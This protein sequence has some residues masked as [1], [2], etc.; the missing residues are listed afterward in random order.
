MQPAWHEQN[1]S[2]AHTHTVSFKYWHTEYRTKTFCCAPE[3]RHLLFSFYI[4]RAHSE[5]RTD[6]VLV[7]VIAAFSNSTR[8]KNKHN[9]SLHSSHQLVHEENSSKICKISYSNSRV[10]S[11]HDLLYQTNSTR[12][13]N[14]IN[15]CTKFSYLTARNLVTIIT[16][17]DWLFQ[18]G[19]KATIAL[20]IF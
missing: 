3:M 6:S 10:H 12:A 20:T 7:A 15:Q 13:R 19:M 9:T 5:T 1:S 11:K 14:T 4:H 17:Q 8:N 16:L 18:L 2:R